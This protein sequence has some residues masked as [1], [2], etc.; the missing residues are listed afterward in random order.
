MP[1]ARLAAVLSQFAGRLVVDRTA[2]AGPHDFDLTWTPEQFRGR[3]PAPGEQTPLVNG[4][5]VDANGPSLFTAVQE[6][7][8][9][10]LESA[11]APV[12]VLVVERAERPIGD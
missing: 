12:E 4:A 6:Q 10:K 8:G 7:L 11:K 5:P 3:P 9:L 2:I 1:V